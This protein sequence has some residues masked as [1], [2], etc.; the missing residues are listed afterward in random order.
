MFDGKMFRELAGMPILRIDL[1]NSELALAEPDPLTLENLR[2][3]S[4]TLWIAAISRFDCDA[5]G[6]ELVRDSYRLRHAGPARVTSRRNFRMSQAPVG[7]RS[8]QRPQCRH[9]SSSLAMMRPVLSPFATYRSCVRLRDGAF[10]RVLRS[11]SS[12]SAV[13][14]M[15]S[16]GQISTQASH[17]MQSFGANTV[18]TSQLRQRCA[19]ANACAASKPSSTSTLMFLSAMETSLSGTL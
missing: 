9:T 13:K 18:C 6:S 5:I 17:S 2:T 8:A 19:S 15:Q 12:P 10:N 4:L 3:K 7:Q 11:V 1:A 16:I 14:V